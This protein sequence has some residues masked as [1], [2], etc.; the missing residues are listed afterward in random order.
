M[1]NVT[2]LIIKY[3]AVFVIMA[4]LLPVFGRTTWTQML[5]I[6]L[7]LTILAYV[8]DDMW[9]L[10]KFGSVV[11]VLA[12]LGLAALVLWGMSEALPQ[13]TISNQGIWLTATVIGI[14]EAVFHWYL[15]L[16]RATGKRTV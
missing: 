16:T 2:N 7:V 5:I 3:I 9:I 12:D 4:L 14:V 11:A 10:P 8:A 13:F 15:L 6:A 1:K